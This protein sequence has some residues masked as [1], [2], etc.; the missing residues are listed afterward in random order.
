VLTAPPGSVLP[1]LL[2]TALL[3]AGCAV[4]ESRRSEPR[5]AHARPERDPAWRG[6]VQGQD[7]PISET[8]QVVVRMG[9]EALG[10][11][12]V[13]QVLSPALTPEQEKEVQRA[14]ARG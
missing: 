4:P 14:F 13:L 7:L 3:A 10:N 9:S 1:G 8:E 11:V 6:T 5:V 2:A 12:V